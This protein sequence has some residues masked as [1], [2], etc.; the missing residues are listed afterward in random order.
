MQRAKL[1]TTCCIASADLAEQ[2]LTRKQSVQRQ[3]LEACKKTAEAVAKKR[4]GRSGGFSVADREEFTARRNPKFPQTATGTVN[5]D[6]HGKA[7]AGFKI[8]KHWLAM[9]LT[10]W[11]VQDIWNQNK[12]DEVRSKYNLSDLICMLKE[13][14]GGNAIYHPRWWRKEDTGVAWPRWCGGQGPSFPDG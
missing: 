4:E 12:P 13:R 1:F 14:N 5:L 2:G 11:S 7:E 3:R 6:G 9:E 8:S 10:E